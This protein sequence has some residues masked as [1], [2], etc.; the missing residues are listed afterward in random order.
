[1]TSEPRV[2]GYLS[3]VNM[4]SPFSWTNQL[5][6]LMITT[7]FLMVIPFADGWAYGADLASREGTLAGCHAAL[8]VGILGS[9]EKAEWVRRSLRPKDEGNTMQ[10]DT[11][12]AAERAISIQ[13]VSE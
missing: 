6:R 3:Q 8:F 9:C 5:T 1:M 11:M 7:A 10:N 13:E 12:R 2:N 4:I